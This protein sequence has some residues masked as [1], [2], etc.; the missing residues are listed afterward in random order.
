MPAGLDR[1]RI[2]ELRGKGWTL[3]DMAEA[4][5]VTQSAVGRVL[6]PPK[7]AEPTE[8]DP[9]LRHALP[10]QRCG[11]DEPLMVLKRVTRRPS[12]PSEP[13]ATVHGWKRRSSVCSARCS[14]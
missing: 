3:S 2:L 9:D 13:R 14:A 1:D 5:G 11:C 12:V 10:A 8:G 4:Y 6:H 7:P